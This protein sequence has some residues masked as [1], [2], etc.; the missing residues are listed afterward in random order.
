MSNRT[1]LLRGPTAMEQDTPPSLDARPQAGEDGWSTPVYFHDDKIDLDRFFEN[2]THVVVWAYAEFDAPRSE[3][4]QVWVGSDESLTVWLDGKQVYTFEGRRRHRL[5]NHRMPITLTAGTHRVLVRAV[6]R[7]GDF[8][9]S[10]KISDDDTNPRY[11]GNTPFG[12]RWS[13]P[14]PSDEPETEVRVVSDSRQRR[15]E[16]FEEQNVELMS[17]GRILL[18]AYLPWYGRASWVRM[19]WPQVWGDQ[20]SLQGTIGDDRIEFSTQNTVAFRLQSEGALAN[21]TGPLQIIVDGAV[22]GI[23]TPGFDELR[24]ALTKAGSWTVTTAE[25]INWDQIAFVGTAGQELTRDS[26]PPDAWDS[27]LG[28]WACDAI[29][30]ATGADVAFRNN[31]GMRTDMPQEP[32]SIRDLFAMNYPNGLMSFQRTG[33]ELLAILEHDVRNANEGPMQISGVSYTFDRSLPEGQRIIS[34]DIDPDRSYTIASEDYSV[35]RGARFFGRDIEDRTDTVSH[36]VDALVR[37]AQHQ[38]TVMAPERGRI[39]EQTP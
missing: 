3:A 14:N 13:V 22:A 27:D 30:F 11:D 2:P 4:A 39:R 24:V 7:R 9:F 23:A 21:I 1:W 33:R 18:S 38:G 17:P 19:E 34:S 35:S 29:R 10:V 12:L 36:T 31:R 26:H 5:P 28:N 8:D 6:Q 16:W 37:Y 20:M 32:I 25:A 15:A